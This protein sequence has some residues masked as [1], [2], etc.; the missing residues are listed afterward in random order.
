MVKT[1][2]GLGD[3]GGVAQHAHGTLHLGQIATGD[4]GGWLVVDANLEASGAPVDEL[5]GTLGLD[6]SNGG[7]DVL[8]DNVSTVQH[9]AG[10]VL[11][12]T[13]IA[14]HHLERRRVRIG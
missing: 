5:D 2:P 8:G 14:L 13:G 3:G 1:S 11:A 10:H 4:N 9:A 12:V 7:V 6:G